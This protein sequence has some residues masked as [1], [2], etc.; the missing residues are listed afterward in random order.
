MSTKARA[1][2]EDLECKMCTAEGAGFMN[3]ASANI[4]VSK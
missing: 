1:Y 3:L 4:L 2:L